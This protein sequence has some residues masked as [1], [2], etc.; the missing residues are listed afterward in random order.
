MSKVRWGIIAMLVACCLP[1]TAV[2]GTKKVGSKARFTDVNPTNEARFIV[3]AVS[4]SKKSCVTGRTVKIK[5]DAGNKISRKTDSQGEFLI[6]IQEWVEVLPGLKYTAT[7]EEKKVGSGKKKALCKSDSA[8]ATTV[9]SSVS[10]PAFS[11]DDGSNS[12]SGVVSADEDVC[13]QNVPVELYRGDVIQGSSNTSNSG[14][15]TIELPVEPPAGTWQ[16]FAPFA[17]LDDYTSAGDVTITQCDQASSDPI[18]I[19]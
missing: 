12:F 14:N 17:I 6:T 4:S 8:K 19:N 5:D 11:F 15:F 10:I 9:V 18:V 3:G 1:A 7:V 16:A 13:S 2:A